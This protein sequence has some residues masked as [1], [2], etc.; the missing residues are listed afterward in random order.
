METK[1]QNTPPHTVVV[2]AGLAG[3]SA[4]YELL[5]TGE[6]RVTVVEARDRVG[7]RV[8]SVTVDGYGADLGGFIIYPWYTTYHALLDELGLESQLQPTP[9]YDIFYEFGSKPKEYIADKDIELPVRE[10]LSLVQKTLVPILLDR[11]VANPRLHDFNHESISQYIDGYAKKNNK[12]LSRLTAFFDLIAQ[13]Y[14]YG[15]AAS[16]KAAFIAPILRQTQ[17]Y[18]DVKKAS[19]FLQGNNT[20]P[21]SLA[22]KI[23]DFGGDIILNETVQSIEP[24]RVTTQHHTIDCDFIILAQNAT[25]ELYAQA[26]PSVPKMEWHYTTFI[27][28]VIDIGTPALINGSEEWIG[29]FYEPHPEKPYH[30]TSATYLGGAY[31]S[32]LSGKMT[33]N[34]QV[35]GDAINEQPLSDDTLYTIVKSEVQGR[36]PECTDIEIITAEYWPWTMPIADELFVEAVRNAQGENG[37]FVAGDYLGTPSMETAVRTGVRAASAVQERLRK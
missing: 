37:I 11:D 14:C 3:L 1:S 8:H 25:P 10:A 35:N 2:G 26:F 15:D 13:G 29:M 24:G 31:G 28:A 9:N 30:M 19:V 36:F 34:I 33:V 5:K 32:L 4:A 7:G 12:D 16:W 17:L 22:K 23:R 21:K 20:V 27:T 6:H 18:G